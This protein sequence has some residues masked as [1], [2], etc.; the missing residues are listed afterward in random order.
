MKKLLIAFYCFSLL[1]PLTAA[2]TFLFGTKSNPEKAIVSEID[3]CYHVVC[4]IKDNGKKGRNQDSLNRLNA[5][6]ICLLGIASY[7][8]GK[9]VSRCSATVRGMTLQKEPE[10]KDEELFF[11]FTVPLDGVTEKDIQTNQ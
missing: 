11:V 9:K 6:K 8:K 1:L 10:K 4:V 2:E 5:Q 7:R 3:G